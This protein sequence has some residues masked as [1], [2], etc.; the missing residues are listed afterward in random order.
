[1]TFPPMTMAYEHRQMTDWRRIANKVEMSSSKITDRQSFGIKGYSPF[2]ALHDFDII[3]QMPIEP[4]HNILL[5]VGKSIVH[6]ILDINKKDRR[7]IDAMKEFDDVW[8]NMKIPSEF[9]R[10][11]RPLQIALKHYKSGE[12]L[13]M[14]VCGFLIF[15]R[16]LV[17]DYNVK[18]RKIWYFFTYI[19]RACLFDDKTY[20]DICQKVDLSAMMQTFYYMFHIVFGSENC[21]FNV[22]LFSHLRETRRRYRLSAVSAEP[23]ESFYSYIKKVIVNNTRSF[24]KQIMQKSYIASLRRHECEKSVYISNNKKRANTQDNLVYT[25]DRSFYKIVEANGDGMFNARRILTSKFMNKDVS[26]LNYSLVGVEKL[27]KYEEFDC[28]ISEKSIIAKAVLDEKIL[29]AVPLDALL[30]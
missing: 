15:G 14:I 17:G 16:A 1:M 21:S 30:S 13:S 5:G 24:S 20:Q 8:I 9:N 6:L 27:K 25:S 2:L 18:L 11:P 26:H 10:R 19:V 4:M 7:T 3:E 22:H 12:Y 28:I 29:I 23:F